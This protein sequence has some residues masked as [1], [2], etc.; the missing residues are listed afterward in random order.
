MLQAGSYQTLTVS[1]ISDHG[2]Y[3]ADIDGEEVLLPNRYVSFGDKVGD[4]KDVFVYHDSENRL[5]ATTENPFVVV[6][7]ADNLT[8]ADK[9]L[10]GTVLDCCIT[11]KPSFFHTA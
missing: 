8:V 5:I 4:T 6:G 11:A 3:L 9:T 7:A 2:L 10:H 1:R